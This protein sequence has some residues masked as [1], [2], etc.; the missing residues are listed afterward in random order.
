MRL[1]PSS[2]LRTLCLVTALANCVG[3]VALLLF[4]RPLFRLLGVPPPVELHS[5]AFVSVLSFTM[6]VGAYYVFRDPRRNIDLLKVGIIGKGLYAFMAYYF[7]AFHQ[8]HWFYLVFG[9]WDYVFVVIFFLYLIQLRSP[10]LAQLQRGDI[11]A[12]LARSVRPRTRQALVLYFSLTGN[13]SKAVA[14]LA[15]GLE[16]QGYEVDLKAIEPLEP[17]F[18]FPLSLGDFVRIIARAAVRRPTRIAP[19]DLDPRRDY[20][21]VVVEAQTWLL[22]MAAPV[23]ALFQAPETRA[24]FRNRDAAALVVCRGAWRRTQAQVVRWLEDCGANVIGARGY[25]HAGSEPAR[26]F[27]LWFY[28]IFREP[29]RPRGLALPHYGLGPET[30]DE[31]ERFG[32]DLALRYPQ[33]RLR[34]TEAALPGLILTSE[35]TR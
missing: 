32:E 14:R 24:L 16:R 7:H 1:V 8:L 29:G 28:L 9:V 11:F 20:D 23:E 19:L 33:A 35:T 27:S 18:R 4:H 22:G 26:L 17:L 25:T 5:F 15:R 6:G 34:P 10:D 21:L 30:L 31:I 13:G 12:G 3:N 2:A